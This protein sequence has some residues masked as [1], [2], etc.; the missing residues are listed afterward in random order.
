MIVFD[1]SQNIPKIVP[2]YKID[3]I[4]LTIKYFNN[5]EDD[6]NYKL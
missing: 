1:F 3:H 4:E 2:A 5:T 6:K